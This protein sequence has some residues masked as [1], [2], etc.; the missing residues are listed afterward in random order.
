[1]ALLVSDILTPVQDTL[2]DPAPGVYW[3]N[4]E[5]VRYANMFL[6]FVCPLMP[7]LYTQR[8]YVTL[9]AGSDQALPADGHTFLDAYFAANGQA[10]FVMN[11]D[12]VKHG[13]FANL[14]QMTANAN[15]KVVCADPRDPRRYHV[16]P[17]NTGAA[18]ALEILYGAFPTPIAALGDT[19]PLSDETQD[20][21][22]WYITNLAYRKQTDRQNLAK[23][24]ECL[25][26]CRA[27]IQARST[28][29]F[30]ESPKADA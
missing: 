22:Y 20:P 2:L 8:S 21:A 29:Q 26:N 28:V 6:R 16:F 17:K 13:K 5:L 27:W 1:M 19:W 25:G 4:A 23:A 3:P 9:V 11:M 12:V 7:Q 14:A 15:P 30:G 18:S 24:D 10:V